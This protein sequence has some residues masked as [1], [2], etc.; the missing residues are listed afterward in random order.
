MF[1]P[2]NP[3]SGELFRIRGWHPSRYTRTRLKSFLSFVC[4]VF[5]FQVE[6]EAK[7]LLNETNKHRN[8]NWD[9]KTAFE[10]IHGLYT[11][12]T[13]GTVGR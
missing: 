2:D 5:L 1:R 13:P 8:Y 12:N 4:F 9:K 11:Y 10:S 3:V 6:G 7:T